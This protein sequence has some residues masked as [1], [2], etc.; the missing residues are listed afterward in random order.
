MGSTVGVVCSVGVG[1]ARGGRARNEDNYLVCE[2]ERA[3]WREGEAEH[4]EPAR[5][6]GLLL[7]VCDG[8]GGHEDGDLASATAVRVLS[9]LYREEIPADLPRAMMRYVLDAHTRLHWK[10][11]EN[12]P[13]T[14]GTTLTAGWMVGRH[15]AWVHVGDSRLY[16]YRAGHLRQLSRDQTR[17]EFAERDGRPATSEG[18]H[19][20]QSF[21]YGSR[22]LGDDSRLR[23]QRDH[24][25]GIEVLEVGDRLVFC[26][27]GLCGVV[28]DA[29]I[30]DVLDHVIDPQAAAVACAERAIARGATDNITVIVVRVDRLPEVG[31]TEDEGMAFDDESTIMI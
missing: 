24:D 2:G 25:A 14:M 15:L 28:D 30:A 9:K 1:A 4:A 10:A 26:T 3:V 13:V 11:R 27:D 12:G 22:G 18:V 20:A 5:G 21:I 17:N 29:S 6:E 23:L 19:L 8:M 16:L 31:A 7:A